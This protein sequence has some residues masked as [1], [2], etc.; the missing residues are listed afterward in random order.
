MFCR[1][2]DLQHPQRI[3][4]LLDNRL[5]FLVIESS[6]NS[7]LIL[8]LSASSRQ[9]GALVLGG[10]LGDTIVGTSKDDI[11]LGG[12]ENHLVGGDGNDAIA[13]GGLKDIIDAGA[14]ANIIVAG[15]G[16]DI[17]EWTGVG[18]TITTG[19]GADTIEFGRGATRC[20]RKWRGQAVYQRADG[21]SQR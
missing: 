1:I 4:T 10:A 2:L 16:D 11:I 5:R 9:K 6:D 21:N 3:E 12:E 7:G 20:R 8:D 15:G 19:V 14:G 17:I 13:G 18:S